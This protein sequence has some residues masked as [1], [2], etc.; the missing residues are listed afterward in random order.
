MMRSDEVQ[1]WCADDD[2][3]ATTRR[4]EDQDGEDGAGADTCHPPDGLSAH[5]QS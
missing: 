5:V 4:R 1:D 3:G 2:S